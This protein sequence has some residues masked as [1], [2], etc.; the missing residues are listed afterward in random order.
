M[1]RADRLFQII[2]LLRRSDLTTAREIARSLEVSERT[3]YRDIR[4]LIAS[5]VHIDGEA[6]VGYVLREFD[7]PPLMF[8]ADEIEALAFGMRMVENWGDSELSAAARRALGK[9]ETVL[10]DDR[11]H[12]IEETALYSVGRLDLAAIPFDVATLRHA[13]REKQR[14]RFDYTDA[15]DNHTSRTIRPLGM[16]FFGQQWLLLAWCELRR[17]FRAFRP[18]R[19]RNPEVLDT[20]PDEPGKTLDDY[21]D[22]MRRCRQERGE[23]VEDPIG[24]RHEDRHPP[25]PA[26][27]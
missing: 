20:F 14:V 12:Q 1:R 10:P 16:I 24:S 19:I 11:K 15:A 2:E 9:I 4:D 27:P 18:D 8:D 22:K 3:V 23:D 26:A 6:G 7:L 21:R 5:G 13:V 25:D 17:D